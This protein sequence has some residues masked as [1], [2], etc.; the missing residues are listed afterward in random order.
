[1]SGWKRG[2]AVECIGEE[3]DTPHKIP[4]YHHGSKEMST[5]ITGRPR[6]PPRQRRLAMSSTAPTTDDEVRRELLLLD[7]RR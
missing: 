5:G 1:M 4:C 3:V 6:L 7:V 2:A